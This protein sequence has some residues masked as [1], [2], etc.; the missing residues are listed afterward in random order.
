MKNYLLSVSVYKITKFITNR[1]IVFTFL[2]CINICWIINEISCRQKLRNDRTSRSSR[3]AVLAI[4]LYKPNIK[5]HLLLCNIFEE[6]CLDFRRVFRLIFFEKSVMPSESQVDDAKLM[7]ELCLVN[8]LNDWYY[9]YICIIINI[10]LV[11]N[12]LDL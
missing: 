7:R 4:R 5:T 6:T 11:F 10:Y 12:Y 2:H 3:C 1:Q 9:N 8:T